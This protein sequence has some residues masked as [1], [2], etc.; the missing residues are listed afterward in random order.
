MT[1][2]TTDRRTHIPDCTFHGYIFPIP[3][4]SYWITTIHLS[5]DATC[6]C[7]SKHHDGDGDLYNA[8]TWHIVDF[9]GGTPTTLSEYLNLDRCSQSVVWV[10]FENSHCV[11]IMGMIYTA[12]RLR[13]H[14][15]VA[16][17]S[18]LAKCHKQNVLEAVAIVDEDTVCYDRK[19]MTR[20]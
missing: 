10:A 8:L 7:V 11:Y 1:Y 14:N 17:P 20:K 4:C 12:T 18:L 16:Q 2:H 6:Q 5:P 13:L 9:P 3:A 19:S 15:G